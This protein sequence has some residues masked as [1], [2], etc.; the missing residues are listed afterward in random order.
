MR[1]IRRFVLAALTAVVGGFVFGSGGSAVALTCEPYQSPFCQGAATQY[2]GGFSPGVGFGGFGGGSCTAVRT[3][4]VFLHGNGDNALGWDSPANTAPAGYTAPGVSVYDYFRS[5]GYTDCELF[6]VT[7]LSA[8]EQATPSL[9]Y[10]S[11]AKLAIIKTFIDKVKAYTGKAKV[12]IVAHSLGS[13]MGLAT[14]DYYNYWGSVNRF[15]NIA[16]AIRGLNS[17]LYTGYANPYVP[18]CG[19][20]NLYNAYIFGF[21]PSTG[22]YAF[23]YNRWTGSVGSQAMRNLPAKGT[24]ISFYTIG[25]GQQDQ[26]HCSTAAGWASCAYGPVFFARSN[27]RAQ[28]NVGAGSTAA[29][30]DLN[31]SDGLWT[32]VAGGDANGVGHFKARNNTGKIIH[33][34]LTTACTGIDCASA[35]T[36]GPKANY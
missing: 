3:P 4:I 24:A 10:H 34:M 31:L 21:Y 1:R 18:T 2:A 6:G 20:E 23:G 33:R 26:V 32:N 7:Y 15:V 36:H 22:V 14:L 8:S 13:T 28:I 11:P 9:N 25:A 29:A 35:Y 5:Q 27:V 16:G 17:C 19:S 30:V 12:D